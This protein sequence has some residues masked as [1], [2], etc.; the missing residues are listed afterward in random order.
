MSAN[1]AGARTPLVLLPGLLEDA[2]VWQHQIDALADIAA[3]IV[4]DLTRHDSIAGMAE[5]VL[6]TA[7]DR[8][9]LAGHSMGG[10]VALAVTRIA[11]R[12]VMRLALVDTAARADTPEQTERRHALLEMARIG[13]FKGV[14]P[15]LLPL[16]VHPDRLEDKSVTE[17]I[18]AMAERVGPEAFERQQTAIMG[19][20]DQRKFLP[21]I[22]CPTLVL[23]GREDQ[24]TPLDRSEEMAAAIPG[25]RL[26]VIE[27]CGHIPHLE[28]PEET[29]AAMREWLTG[30]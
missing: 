1:P 15:R 26:V 2:A 12:R 22:A 10:Y 4:A 5:S 29:T 9:A 3:P 25:A 8:F 23:C 18:M 27:R 20:I 17:V 30:E 13:K 24:I 11:P 6:A 28:R 16:L 14:T 21:R 19:R 7:P